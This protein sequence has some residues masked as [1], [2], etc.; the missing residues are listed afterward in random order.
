MSGKTIAGECQDA[1]AHWARWAA[2]ASDDTIPI[3][4]RMAA[5]P[6]R[7]ADIPERRT[8]ATRLGAKTQEGDQV[9]LTNVATAFRGE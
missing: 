7:H 2:I 3:A 5:R 8:I 6:D 1:A 4:R 9:I